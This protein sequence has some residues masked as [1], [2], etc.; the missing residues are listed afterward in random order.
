E[1]FAGEKVEVGEDAGADKQLEDD[2]ELH[3]LHEVRL[4]GFVNQVRDIEERLVG[5]ELLDAEELEEAEGQA[6]ERDDKAPLEDGVAADAAETL[7][8]VG[9]LREVKLHF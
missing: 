7:K 3:L 9:Q 1:R 5:R 4:A 6:E 8:R 2:Q